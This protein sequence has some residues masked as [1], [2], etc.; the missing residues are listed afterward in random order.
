MTGTNLKFRAEEA[1]DLLQSFGILS[2]D[3][4][5]LY[6]HPVET[7]TS[8]LPLASSPLLSSCSIMERETENEFMDTTLGLNKEEESSEKI[9]KI[10][11]F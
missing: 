2:L 5:K 3:S 9:S 11:F 6:V 1:I 8:L 4:Q 10:K 7:A